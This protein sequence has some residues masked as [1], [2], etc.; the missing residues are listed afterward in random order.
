[1]RFFAD[2]V[3]IH[4]VN[5]L[6]PHE[7]NACDEIDEEERAELKDK[8]VEYCYDGV[9]MGP[10]VCPICGDPRVARGDFLL[11]CSSHR[12]GGDKVTQCFNAVHMSCLNAV[13]GY[14]L[15]QVRSFLVIES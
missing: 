11:V 4:S 10:S 9:G 5:T 8:V 6:V 1:M 12:F 15:K 2:F 3:L 13:Y 7:A 14:D